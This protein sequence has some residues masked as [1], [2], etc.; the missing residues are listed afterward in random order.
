M[1]RFDLVQLIGAKTCAAANGLTQY[2][3]GD[4]ACAKA[5]VWNMGAL[6]V[7]AAAIALV[8]LVIHQRRRDKLDY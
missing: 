8:V 3:Y 6:V 2:I 1:D 4:A 5:E 7:I